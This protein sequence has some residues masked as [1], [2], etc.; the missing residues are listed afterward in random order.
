MHNMKFKFLIIGL[1]LA[2]MTI[3]ISAD[4]TLGWEGEFSLNQLI[5]VDGEE[6]Y[7]NGTMELTPS[8]NI[9]WMDL[10]FNAK[11]EFSYLIPEYQIEGNLKEFSISYTTESFWK[12]NTGRFYYLP[13]TSEFFPNTNYFASTD[14][15]QLIENQGEDFYSAGDML[16]LILSGDSI[17][18]TSTLALSPIQMSAI[19]LESKWFPS[20]S[21]PNSIYTLGGDIYNQNDI[22]MNDPESVEL[23]WKDISVGFEGGWNTYLFDLSLQYYHGR[24]NEY[25]YQMDIDLRDDGLFDME[26]TPL[27]GDIY[28]SI[29]L[30]WLWNINTMYIWVDGA[31]NFNKTFID[32][33]LRIPGLYTTTD[34]ANQLTSSL[35]LRYDFDWQDLTLIAE[36]KDSY[37][38]SDNDDLIMPFFSSALAGAFTMAIDD[39]RHQPGGF[40]LY[41][42]DD[43]SWISAL[44]WKYNIREY[45]SLEGTVALLMGEQD[46]FF[47]QYD[48]DIYLALNLIWRY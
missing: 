26:I 15:I 33:T 34:N 1:I 4:S 7:L 32:S 12:I 37:I 43:K 25:L 48:Q 27:L 13:S 28:D 5:D 36:W 2:F 9:N 40:I 20:S 47:G 35:G 44:Q 41:S 14:Y 29:G 39:Y 21:I 3:K 17:Y 22:S 11:A 45:F 46:S 8:L 38:L 24:G 19:D 31:F 16:Q 30:N 6:N 42:L 23:S 10:E 18:L